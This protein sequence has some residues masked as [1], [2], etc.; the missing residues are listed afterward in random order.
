MYQ[1]KTTQK[2]LRTL[3]VSSLILYREFS[4]T[5]R[6]KN[7]FKT[8]RSNKSYFTEAIIFLDSF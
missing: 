4:K 5:Y 8:I 7:S 3:I 6:V 1:C 2:K